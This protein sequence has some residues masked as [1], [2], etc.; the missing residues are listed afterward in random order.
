MKDLI[1]ALTLDVEQVFYSVYIV[2]VPFQFQ[3]FFTTHH[4]ED[5]LACLS[6]LEH[7][8]IEQVINLLVVELHK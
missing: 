7:V 4:V 3:A 2:L 1:D 5:H 6:R 8:T